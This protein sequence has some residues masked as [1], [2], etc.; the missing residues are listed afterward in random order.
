MKKEGGGHKA[1][2]PVLG[3]SSETYFAH[4]KAY[5]QGIC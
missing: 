5:F 4:W 1:L 3:M 2:R